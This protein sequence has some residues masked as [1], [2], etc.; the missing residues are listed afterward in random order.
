MRAINEF[1]KSVNENDCR[2]DIIAVLSQT[3]TAISVDN[4]KEVKDLIP[5]LIMDLSI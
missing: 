4:K 2:T 1:I 3:I 5:K